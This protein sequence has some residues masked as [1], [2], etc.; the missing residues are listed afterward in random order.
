[1]HTAPS[2]VPRHVLVFAQRTI[3]VPAQEGST[4]A[5]GA[6]HIR[7]LEHCNSVLRALGYMHLAELGQQ[8]RHGGRRR[9]GRPGLLLDRAAASLRRRRIRGR[10]GP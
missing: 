7:A 1:M 4:A 6:H 5:G 2:L 10:A 8:A 3:M 9:A